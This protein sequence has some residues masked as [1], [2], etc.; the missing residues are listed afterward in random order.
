M[1][2]LRQ[3]RDWDIVIIPWY[4][5]LVALLLGLLVPHFSYTILPHLLFPISDVTSVAFLTAE[6]TGMMALTGIMFSFLFLAISFGSSAY[7]PRLPGALVTRK[8]VHTFGVF[9]G[10][11]VYALLVLLVEGISRGTEGISALTLLVAIGW[12]LASLF[13]L[14]R[15]IQLSWL[16]TISHVLATLGQ[17]GQR[18][19]ARIYPPYAAPAEKTTP[20]IPVAPT[21][22]QIYYQGL[23]LYVLALDVPRLVSL[24]RDADAVIRVPYAVGDMVLDGE[25]LASVHGARVAIAEKALRRA[26][27]MGQE[28]TIA[29]DPMFALRLLVDIAIRG[30]SPSL[31][32]PTTAVQALNQIEALL[33][34]LGNAQLDIGQVYDAAG[35]LRL[36]YPAPSWEDYLTLGLLEILQYG[37]ASVQVQR[38]VG[39]LLQALTARLPEARRPAL[40]RFASE[41]QALIRRT[42]PDSLFRAE[43]EGADRRGIGHTPP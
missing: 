3:L 2:R 1:V 18:E 5:V 43:A 16:I 15:L 14:F 21:T 9:A 17:D 27:M 29:Y 6:A 39:A 33:L 41:R 34:Q 36:T 26:I 4:Y 35:M 10:T 37:A 25:T 8:M 31:N 19:I 42:F 40:A 20:Y 23:P 22:Q 28:R 32:D 12:L 13:I 7:T 24:A 38:R 30:L 11:F